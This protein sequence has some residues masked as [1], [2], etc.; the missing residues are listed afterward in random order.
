M[1]KIN[2]KDG[3]ASNRQ[4]YPSISSKI[5]K[6][7]IENIV[8][9]IG[10]FAAI[11]TLLSGIIPEL[12]DWQ[13]K[14]CNSSELAKDCI[15]KSREVFENI[16]SA[17]KVTFYTS[18]SVAL[19]CSFWLFAQ[20][21]KNYSRGKSDNR[22]TTRNNIKRR[23]AGLYSALSMKTLLK[24]RAGGLMHSFM[25]FGFL[26]LLLAT[27]LLEIDHQLPIPL[28]FLVGTTY[29]V[30]SFF[31]DLSGVF[32]LIGCFWAIERRY[33]RK[34]SRVARKTERQDLTNIILLI[35]L[36]VG[37]FLVE[38]LRIA[39]NI[40]FGLNM[41][42]EKWSFVSY[43]I[44]RLF[45]NMNTSTDSLAIL[46]RWAWVFHVASFL[47]FLIVLP[48]TKL[49]HM[50][51]A[52][53]NMYLSDTDRPEGSLTEIENLTETEEETF[54][55]GKVSSFTW[56]QLLDTDSCTVCGRCT[57][58]CPAN[59]TGKVLDPR[60]IILSIN[61]VMTSSGQDKVSPTVTS[62]DTPWLMTI[63]SDDIT[64]RISSQ[65]VFGCTSCKACDEVCPVNIEIMDKIID[66]RRHYTLM[67]SEFP[68]ELGNAF[69]GMENQDNPWG[70]DQN[71]RADWANSIDTEVN[72]IDPDDT[73]TFLN[74]NGDFAYDVLYWVGCSG[75]FDDRAKKTT[76]ALAG[77][78]ERAGI[79]FAILGKH[80]KCNG[81]PARRSGNEYVFQM[82]ALSNIETLNKIGPPTILSACPH[83]FNILKNEYGA[84]GGNYEVV[85]HTQYLL[86]LIEDGKLDLSNA[87][88]AERVA[89]HD[90]CY[91]TRH[92]NI[93]DEPR[94]IIGKLGGIE[95]IEMSDN[96]K[97]GLCC[98]AGGAQFFME[99][100]GDQRINI[101][102]SKQALDTGATTVISEC[103]FCNV[104]M[105]DGVAAILSDYKN[106]G[107]DDVK[108]K[109][110]AVVLSEALD[111][112]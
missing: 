81:D 97:S 6:Y 70:L 33:I 38:A 61:D 39:K 66:I 55:A 59:L 49:R 34:I 46:H 11:F 25:Y 89:L 98:G 18:V 40:S 88:F 100:Q 91:L 47:I 87:K 93:V 53:I 72:I 20:R 69:R 75:S 110:L 102:R 65:E 85:H 2:F 44:A 80:E 32:F 21:T 90:S 77:L 52:P 86:K 62:Q 103:P 99:E 45:N 73:K 54:G 60:Q 15:I 19:A 43:P 112:E 63:A 64:S 111:A 17:M 31:G 9:G 82:L 27:T 23:V 50:V 107:P 76:Q 71:T 28:K 95:V 26:G 13:I 109:D 106:T 68:N 101:K 1:S 16:P 104:M 94:K 14:S 48:A 29:Q 3:K 22:K 105:G 84:F 10:I 78:L 35:L 79:K 57:D 67:E 83:C 96:K 12:I 41:N 8:V 5:S 58:V 30:Y 108:V 36:G 74:E 56:K 4:S 42:H 7:G 24:D 37:G 51:T 92:N